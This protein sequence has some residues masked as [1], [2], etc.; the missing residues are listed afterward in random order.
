MVGTVRAA[1]RDHPHLRTANA[2][3]LV[4]RAGMGMCQ[5]R[6][7]QPALCAL[8]AAET[9]QDVAAVGSYTARP[10]VKPIPLAALSD[11]D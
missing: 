10:P 11:T 8:V 5:G 3:K 4:T 1:L 7:C 2:V 9:G 6:S